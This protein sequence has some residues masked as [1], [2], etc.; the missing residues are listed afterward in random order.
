MTLAGHRILLVEDEVLIAF[1]IMSIIREANGE[2]LAHATSLAR[3]M[4]LA[5]SPNLS[6][7]ILDFRLGRRTLCP[8]LRSCMPPASL[9]SFTQPDRLRGCFTNL[10]A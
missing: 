2:V 7:A 10:W 1:D 8:L 5:A 6:L 4:K 3:A 9:S